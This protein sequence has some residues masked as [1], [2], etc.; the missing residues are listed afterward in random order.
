MPPARQPPKVQ[1]NRLRAPQPSIYLQRTPVTAA[2]P[3]SLLPDCSLYHEQFYH[4]ILNISNQFSHFLLVLFICTYFFL[5]FCAY[6]QRHVIYDAIIQDKFIHIDEQV[7]SFYQLKSVNIVQFL[8]HYVLYY[9]CIYYL[10]EYIL[11]HF[12]CLGR[13][14]PCAIFR[15]S[16]AFFC[17]IVIIENRRKEVVL[18]TF[19]RTAYHRVPCDTSGLH[20]PLQNV[21]SIIPRESGIITATDDTTSL[22]NA[23]PRYKP[24]IDSTTC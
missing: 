13:C 3:V 11:V 6:H 22:V 18:S 17:E 5:L 4:L 23:T 8:F 2:C 19:M 10:N 12:T 21:S 14:I 9:V 15:P 20:P 1:R 24:A 7:L 16:I